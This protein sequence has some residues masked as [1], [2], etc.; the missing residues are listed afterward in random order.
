VWTCARCRSEG[1][2]NFEVCWKCGASRPGYEDPEFDPNLDGM[3]SAEQYSA[4]A[5]ARAHGRFVTLATFWNPVEAHVLVGR[6]EAAGI[7]AYVAD[8]ETV[9]MDW[10]LANAVGG[11]KVQVAEPDASRAQQVL[12]EA[13]DR[14][15]AD[16]EDEDE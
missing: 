14:H 3:V 11:V 6:L 7:R 8:A 1:E 13:A 9:A 10:L 4:E 5:A 2:D 16:A 12:A 15:D